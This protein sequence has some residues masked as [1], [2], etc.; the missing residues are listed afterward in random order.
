MTLKEVLE[1]LEREF[2]GVEFSGGLALIY[3]K[4]RALQL[5]WEVELTWER[6]GERREVRVVDARP[7]ELDQL[8]A[9]LEECRALLANE[10]NEAAAL[11]DQLHEEEQEN[12]RLRRDFDGTFSYLTR[13]RQI[14]EAMGL[15]NGAY[16]WED[17]LRR[18]ADLFRRN[19]DLMDRLA[20][21]DAAMACVRDVVD[22][23]RREG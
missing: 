16:G 18:G 2:V 7:V 5:G 10:R 13:R 8:R 22:Q 21:S 17:L 14:G 9:H 12:V 6:G 15:T 11:A 19:E 20:I 3:M 23:H 4:A 1:T